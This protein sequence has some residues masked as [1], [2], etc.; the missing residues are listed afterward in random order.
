MFYLKNKYNKWRV[1]IMEIRYDTHPNDAKHYT[2]D[3]L[4]EAYLIDPVFLKDEIKLVYSHV[5]RMIAGGALPVE[6]SLALEAGKEIGTNYFLE[7]REMGIINIGGKGSVK[8]DGK[9][10]TLEN[11]DGL[12]VGM[13]TKEIVFESADPANPAKFYI[14]SFSSE[15]SKKK[16]PSTIMGFVTYIRS[17]ESFFEVPS[18]IT[19]AFAAAIPVIIIINKII[20]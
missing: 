12:Y 16:E 14:N 4:R 13:G 7:R 6:K 2:T 20:T 8:L 19:P 3:R 17:S 11:R 9:V 15:Y 5:D 18:D 1:F 10:F